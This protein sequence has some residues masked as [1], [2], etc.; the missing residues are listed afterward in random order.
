[1]VLAMSILKTFYYGKISIYMKIENCTMLQKPPTFHN[2]L[3]SSSIRW[4]KANPKHI[5]LSENISKRISQRALKKK[6]T[7]SKTSHSQ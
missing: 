3:H 4:A 6:A 1:M 5:I 7:K 2:K